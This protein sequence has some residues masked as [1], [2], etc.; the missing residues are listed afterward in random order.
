MNDML[1]AKLKHT[2]K[3]QRS[4]EDIHR[5]LDIVEYVLHEAEDLGITTSVVTRALQR[6]QENPDQDI[7]D[8]IVNAIEDFK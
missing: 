5:S 2:H 4:V 6:M 7:S 8:A 1:F 3:R